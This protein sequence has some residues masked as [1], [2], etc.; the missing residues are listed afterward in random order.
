M[1]IKPLGW[2][3]LI[4]L[5]ENIAFVYCLLS[6]EHLCTYMYHHQRFY[7]MFIDIH[8]SYLKNFNINGN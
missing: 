1:S 8:K 2:G 6:E 7:G 4:S 3:I 5:K